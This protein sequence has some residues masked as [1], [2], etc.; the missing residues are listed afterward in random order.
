MAQIMMAKIRGWPS[1]P[2]T[3][4]EHRNTHSLCGGLFSTFA[5]NVAG[6]LKELQCVLQYKQVSFVIRHE[7]LMQSGHLSWRQYDLAHR[8]GD[9][10]NLCRISYLQ[11]FHHTGV[12]ACC[13]LGAPFFRLRCSFTVA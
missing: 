5:I 11:H 9:V 12:R 4:Q 2:A 6:G 3:F 8:I 10:A 13:L 7:T 1:S